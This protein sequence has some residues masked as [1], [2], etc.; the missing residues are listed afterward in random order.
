MSDFYF[1]NFLF[2]ISFILK[3]TRQKQYK[4]ILYIHSPINLMLTSYVIIV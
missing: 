2:W 1:F 4:K 3:E